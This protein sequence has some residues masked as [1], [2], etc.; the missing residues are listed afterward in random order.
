MSGHPYFVL[1]FQ[2]KAFNHSLLS[3]T[4]AVSLS[5]M[6]FTMLRYAPSIPKLLRFFFYHECM[7]NFV[8]WFSSIY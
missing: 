2:E 6:P 3:R 5:L 8:K 4:L 7:L 1:D